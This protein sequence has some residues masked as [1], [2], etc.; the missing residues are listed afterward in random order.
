[1]SDETLPPESPRREGGGCFSKLLFLLLLLG[2][3]GLGSAIS[4][5]LRAQDL[6][7]LSSAAPVAQRDMKT[8]LQNAID[9]QY[10]LTLSEAEINQWLARTLAMRQGGVLS[11]QVKLKRVWVR[12]EDGRAE[13]IMERRVLGAPFTVSMYLQVERVESSEGKATNIRMEGGPYH[14]DAPRPPK[15]G[16][17]G[18]LVV[19][20]GFLLLVLPAY[21]NLAKQFPEELEL[22]IRAMS[23]IT[24][25]KGKIILDPRETQ[26]NLGMPESF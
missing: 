5:A 12:L 10:A 22:G 6:S 9:R 19:P 11:D 2:A 4:F 7:D 24:I 15:G 13:V 14:P 3:A 26:G 17:F 23:R 20:Q 8:V 18:R 25:E 1:M 16:R 21:K